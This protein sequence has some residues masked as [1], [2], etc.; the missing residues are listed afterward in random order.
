MKEQSTIRQEI[1]KVKDTLTEHHSESV[2]HDLR[3]KHE[4]LVWV[5][6]SEQE[7]EGRRR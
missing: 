2:T 7:E 4:T 1:M 5:L 3:I 6:A